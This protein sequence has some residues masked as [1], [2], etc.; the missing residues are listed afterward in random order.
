LDS[1]IARKLFGKTVTNEEIRGMGYEPVPPELER[2]AYRK[3]TRE[4]EAMIS[5]TSGGKLSRWAARK[6]NERKVRN[7]M[8]KESRKKNRGR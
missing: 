6:R 3:L 7:R 1:E 2:A 8:T 4:S 5:L